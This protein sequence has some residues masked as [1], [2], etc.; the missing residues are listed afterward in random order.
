MRFASTSRSSMPPAAVRR[1][2]AEMT[3]MRAVAAADASPAWCLAQSAISSHAAG[4]LDAKI[5]REVFAVDPGRGCV[6][7]GRSIQREKLLREEG[8]HLEPARSAERHLEVI[9]GE[10]RD[11]LRDCHPLLRVKT[12]AQHPEDKRVRGGE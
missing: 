5:A 8:T 11:R 10:G 4:F 7:L 2:A 1:V 12:Q 3:V 6:D 9:A